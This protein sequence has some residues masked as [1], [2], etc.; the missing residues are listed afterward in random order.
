MVFKITL[1][2]ESRISTGWVWITFRPLWMHYRVGKNKGGVGVKADCLKKGP[3]PTGGMPSVGG[4]SNNSMKRW[5][6]ELLVLVKL[7]RRQTFDFEFSS[8]NRHYRESNLQGMF[9]T[10]NLEF[11]WKK[12]Y[13][14]YSF[15][16][17]TQEKCSW[18]IFIVKL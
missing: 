3:R 7:C 9:F 4:L 6:M 2:I 17:N 1:L 8:L 11:F 18:E 16:I 15:W 13:K 10:S 12:Y 14:S 5:R